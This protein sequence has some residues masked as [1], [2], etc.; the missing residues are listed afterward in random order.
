MT[1]VTYNSHAPAPQVDLVDVKSKV[2]VDHVEL[3][4]SPA[5]PVADDFM[6]DFKYN[7]PLPTPQ[8]LGINIPAGC[9]AQQAAESIV[10]LLSKAMI[11]GDATAFGDLFL[12]FGKS[13]KFKVWEE[14][15]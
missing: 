11:A 4:A 12:E 7:H 3:E 9:D 1:T 5:P 10:S 8:S 14:Y 15:R 13:I 6:Y 2:V